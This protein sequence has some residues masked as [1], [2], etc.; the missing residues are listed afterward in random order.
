MMSVEL[1]ILVPYDEWILLKKISKIH[2]SCKDIPTNEWKRLKNIEK[3]HKLCESHNKNSKVNSLS[4]ADGAGHCVN[5]SGDT[6]QTD[7]SLNVN[8]FVMPTSHT[9]GEPN[10]DSKSESFE[11]NV[12]VDKATEIPSTS[13]PIK[14][15]AKSDIIQ[16]VQE[17]YKVD[18]STLLDKL[19]KYP[20][21]FSFDSNGIVSISGTLYPGKLYP[22]FNST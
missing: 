14:I 20:N 10:I 22:M 7:T 17:K 1:K 2:E 9:I 21:D 13:N 6:S 11:K 12:I 5:E 4:T 15:L 19:S 3:E 18:A 8:T 16:H